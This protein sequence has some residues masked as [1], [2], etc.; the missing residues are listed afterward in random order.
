MRIVQ[1][2]TRPQRRGAEIF[3]AQLSEELLKLGHQVTLISLF[4]SDQALDFVGEQVNLNLDFKGKIDIQGFKKLAQKLREFNPEVVQANASETLRMC[5]GARWF[6]KGH[7]HLI[8]RNANQIGGFLKGSLRR[9]WNKFLM[10]QVDVVISVSESTRSD[11]IKSV[12][13]KKKV[14]VLP[15]GIDPEKINQSLSLDYP[16][17]SAP[18]LIQ[19]GSL[20]QEKD[21]LGMIDMFTK[22]QIPDLKLIFLGSG[23]LESSL[24]EKVLRLGLTSQVILVPNQTNIFPYLAHALALVMP[25][26]VEGLPG[27]IL[28]AMYCKV[29]VIAYGVGGIPEVLINQKTGWCIP[30]GNS[31]L[32]QQAISALQGLEPNDNAQLLANAHHLTLQKFTI[33][34]ISNQFEVLYQTLAR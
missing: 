10:S 4:K 20:V 22:L 2:I 33:T 6:Y 29:P 8:Y 11:F 15:I 1:V 17:I 34:Q 19:I 9:I 7:Y 27:V 23:P 28:E 32:F 14:V 31:K 3:A 21:P 12:G 18:Y 26:K 13:L 25:S 30:A 16:P 5:V 24:R